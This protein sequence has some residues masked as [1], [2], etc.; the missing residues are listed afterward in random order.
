M[1]RYEPGTYPYYKIKELD[2]EK[3]RRGNQR[4]KK[5]REFLHNI[6]AFDIETTRIEEVE[7]S[8]MYVWQF[9]IEGVGVCIGRTWPEFLQFLSRVRASLRGRWLKVFVH[10]LSYEFQFLRG[11]YDFQPDDVFIIRERKILK[12]DMMEHF[13][14]ACSYLQTNQSLASFT[15][16]FEHEKTTFDYEK[17]RYPWTPLDDVEIEYITNDVVGLIEAMRHRIDAG[18]DTIYTLPATST[19]YVRRV[20]KRA[21]RGFNTDSL[22]EMLPDPQLYTMLREAFR[23]GDV[24]ASRFYA[25]EIVENV[26]SW[27]RSSSYPDVII[28]DKFPMGEWTWVQHMSVD[29]FLTHYMGRRACI[30]RVC[31][32][33]VRLINKAWPSPYLA[34]A[35]CRDVV[36]PALDNGRI[37]SCDYCLTTMTDVDFKIFL[38]EYDF[39]DMWFLE[40]A[41]AAYKKLPGPLRDVVNGLYKDKTKLKGVEG[42]EERYAR[43]KEMINAVYGMMVQDPA[44]PEIKYINGDYVEEEEPLAQRL[45]RANKRAFLSY[46]WGIWVTA[47][48]R[49]RL[50]EAVALVGPSRFVYCDTDSVKFIDDGGADFTRYNEIR[51]AASEKNGAF[52]V[53]PKGNTHYMGVYEQEATAAQFRTW[54]AKKYAYYDQ[55]GALHLTCAGVGKKKGV[56]ELERAGGLAA[57]KEGFIFVDAGGTESVYN[58]EPEIDHYYVDGYKYVPITTN[59]VIRPSTYTVGLSAEYREL[60]YFVE[61]FN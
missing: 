46:A 33:N 20:A 7:Q 57:F 24:H 36:R 16:G 22:R 42:A 37:L 18:G 32:T 21:M 25:G 35:K 60:L 5:R 61:R 59:V 44:R 31:F 26:A 58:D 2:S 8:V 19:G 9:A 53:D 11:V 49:Y 41:H 50:Y 43:S 6:A 15:A 39:D 38:A 4:T 17:K 34:Y 29:D 30:F 47:W 28:N 1:D 54:G 3:R 55:G 12:C 45:E 10:N 14:F 51:R 56:E 27:D 13:E 23:G 48:A 52:A 40:F